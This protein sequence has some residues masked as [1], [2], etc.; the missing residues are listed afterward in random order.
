MA[1]NNKNKVI[2]MCQQCLFMA[3]ENEAD[4]FNHIR[5]LC[6]ILSDVAALVGELVE[7]QESMKDT[8]A[9]LRYLNAE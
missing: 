9:T 1:E 3:E 6:A 5:H 4:S 7:Y 2:D 8:S